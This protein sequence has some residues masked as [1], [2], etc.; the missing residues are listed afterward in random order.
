MKWN[1]DHSV[2]RK[3]NLLEVKINDIS[4]NFAFK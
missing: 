1:G 3:I 4:A 2:V